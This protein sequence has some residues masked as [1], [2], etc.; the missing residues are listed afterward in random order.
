MHVKNKHIDQTIKNKTQQSD[1][2]QSLVHEK[3][4]MECHYVARIW[5]FGNHPPKLELS[6]L[7][8]G[9]KDKEFLSFISKKKKEGKIESPPIIMVTRKSN[10]LRESR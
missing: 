7:H 6:R 1:K 9:G 2:K 3:S 4:T 8:V 10:S 5:H